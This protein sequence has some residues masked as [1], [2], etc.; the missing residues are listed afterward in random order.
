MNRNTAPE[1]VK[2][3]QL[4][5]VLPQEIKL[6]MMSRF[7]MKEVKDES[8]KIRNEVR[9]HQISDKKISSKAFYSINYCW[10]GNATCCHYFRRN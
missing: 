6:K 3:K 1:I 10:S 8:V 7:W 4:D 2:A 5:L 9:R